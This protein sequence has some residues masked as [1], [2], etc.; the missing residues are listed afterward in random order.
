MADNY[1]YDNTG[2]KYLP[3]IRA[4]EVFTD[5]NNNKP[6]IIVSQDNAQPAGQYQISIGNDTI[7]INPNGTQTTPQAI[8][9][10]I[11]GELK[12]VKEIYMGDSNN[13]PQL[14]KTF[15]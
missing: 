4:S 12:K 13:K 9:V 6:F 3:F 8:Y 15:T 11:N 10:K 2:N 14:I 5:E 7:Y 1:I